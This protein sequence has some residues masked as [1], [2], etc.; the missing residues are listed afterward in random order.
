LAA[1]LGLISPATLGMGCTRFSEPVSRLFLAIFVL[2]LI[3]SLKG[4]KWFHP[5]LAGFALGYA[6]NTRPVPAV[7]FG[8]AG[9]LFTSYLLFSSK[10]NARILKSIAP[11]L[12]PFV[13]MIGL[14]M[15]W[16][17]Y[18]TGD[19]FKFTH[20][21][22]QPYDKFGFGKRMEGLDPDLD[23]AVTFTPAYAVRRI[24]RY[25]IPCV[26]YNTLG[27]GYYHPEQ[28]L[29]SLKYSSLAVAETIKKSVA[30]LFNNERRLYQLTG[31]RPWDT[32]FDIKSRTDELKIIVRAIGSVLLAFPMLLILIPL[33]HA[34][35]NRY[36]LLFFSFP[37]L[38]L[39]ALFPLFYDRCESGA[40]PIDARYYNECTLLGIIPLIARGISVLYGWMHKIPSKLPSAMILMFSALLMV[41]TVY[42][43]VRVGKEYRDWGPIYQNL[44]RLVKRQG[45]HHVVIFIPNQ[46]HAPMGDYPFKSL[47]EADIIYF[48]LGPSTTW[49]LTSSDWRAVYEKYFSGRRP[50]IYKDGQLTLLTM[51]DG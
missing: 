8:V 18:F 19:P 35:R 14:C 6:F 29:S 39:V 4:G 17:D 31:A 2:C 26:L 47:E 33:F 38:S 28:T 21:A 27:W 11:F 12:I 16:N 46:R 49:R 22:T 24:W 34:S 45:I 30:D 51:Q 5:P 25:T 1:I 42:T 13:L 36:D 50:Y 32:K 9:A 20:N 48:K 3:H 23:R 15:A 40:T 37:I 10:I 7:A 44:P 43:Y 41:N